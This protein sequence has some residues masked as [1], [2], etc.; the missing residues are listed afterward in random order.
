MKYILTTIA[1]TCTILSFS[2]NIN[3]SALNENQKNVSYLNLGYDFGITTQIGYGYQLKVFKPILLTADFSSPMGKILLDDFKVR[4]GG[5]I[6]IYKINNFTL[7]AKAY[8]IT[9]KHKTT[10]VKMTSFGLEAAAI[11][12]FYK[13]T[14]HLAGEFGIDNSI[15]T[16]LK[17][18][19]L[20]KEN[21]PSIKDGWLS[22]SGGHFYF[23]IQGSR[24]IKEKFEI[25][26][27]A[28]STKSKSKDENA[29]LPYYTQLG[30][31]YK[32]SS[33]KKQQ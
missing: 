14:W 3:W 13:S 31:I 17:H 22:G 26:L 4:I 33:K 27:R 18:S 16:K 15:N 5:Q 19:D 7:S 29:I 20:M 1:L 25:S 11:L 24:T 6:P 28:G 10:L 32:F 2:Q 9:R 12:G 23:G 30:F 21:Y 8:S